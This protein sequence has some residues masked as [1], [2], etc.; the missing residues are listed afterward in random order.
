MSFIKKLEWI[1]FSIF[2]L[3]LFIYGSYPIWENDHQ[4]THKIPYISETFLTAD[5]D[6]HSRGLSP[7]YHAAKKV[8]RKGKRD[9]VEFL[10]VIVMVLA[11]WIKEMTTPRDNDTQQE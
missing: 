10:M 4:K 8:L 11:F 9:Y 7:N 2:L 6:W 5:H 3:T 1:L